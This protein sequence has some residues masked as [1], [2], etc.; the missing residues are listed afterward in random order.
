MTNRY[1]F[2]FRLIKIM[3]NI[4]LCKDLSERV[5]L[6]EPLVRKFFPL[7]KFLLFI[8]ISECI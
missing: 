7:K 4:T 3:S 5:D 1:S 8:F 2:S 6:C